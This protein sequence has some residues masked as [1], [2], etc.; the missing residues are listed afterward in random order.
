MAEKKYF[1]R[2][3][4]IK[5]IVNGLGGR[6]ASNYITVE[7]HRVHY[8]RRYEPSNSIDSGWSFHSREETE[9]YSKDVSNY[10]VYDVNTIAN[11]DRDIIPFLRAPIGSEF[12]R[13][14]DTG[15]FEEVT[16]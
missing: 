8:M 9:E 15:E 4:Q 13:N 16:D 6:I 10:T 1:L 14:E 5:P 2:A 12:E 7:G 11:C 3:D